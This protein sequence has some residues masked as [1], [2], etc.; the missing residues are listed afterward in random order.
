M[1]DDGNTNNT[2]V[3]TPFHNIMKKFYMSFLK[4]TDKGL[5]SCNSALF[6]N[7]PWSFCPMMAFSFL[8][9]DGWFGA[10][11]FGFGGSDLDFSGANFCTFCWFLLSMLALLVKAV[12]D[13]EVEWVDVVRPVGSTSVFLR[14]HTILQIVAPI[15]VEK[16]Q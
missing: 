15:F 3:L 12:R 6:F 1:S 4:V 8:I 14:Q 7:I 16:R 5:S 13:W 2:S 11:G 10:V 9:G